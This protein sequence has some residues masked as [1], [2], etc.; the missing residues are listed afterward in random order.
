MIINKKS[1]FLIL[2]NYFGFPLDLI[3]GRDFAKKN[4]LILIEDNTH[5]HYGI[6]KGKYLG[7]FG[8]YG[9]TSPR[10][11]IQLNYG[12]F[13]Y[14]NKK[15]NMYDTLGIEYR[16]SFTQKLKFN[17]SKNFLKLKLLLKNIYKIKIH[18]LIKDHESILTVSRLDNYSKKI[19]D[20]TDWNYIKKHKL[21]NYENWKIFAEKNKL[22]SLIDMDVGNLNPWAYPVLVSSE[23]EAID[24]INW[25]IKNNLIVFNWPTIHNLVDKNSIAFDL[26]KRIICFSTYIAK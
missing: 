14:S 23:S 12:G 20:N 11:H 13:L 17:V 15:I 18:R 24:W 19:I 10:K 7:T 5:G 22:V 6:Y 25:G 1:K 16:T 4:N 21:R 8:N 26:S 3:K 9:V 2:V